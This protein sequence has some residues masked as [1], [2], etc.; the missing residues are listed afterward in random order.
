MLTVVPCVKNHPHGSK[1]APETIETLPPFAQLANGRRFICLVLAGAP[2]LTSPPVTVNI[3][4]SLGLKHTMYRNGLFVN[5]CIETHCETDEEQRDTIL[6]H[7][8]NVVCTFQLGVPHLRGCQ[9]DPISRTIAQWGDGVSFRSL[10][11]PH[12]VA[13]YYEGSSPCLRSPT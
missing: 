7:S 9:L 1:P 12:P 3:S 8:L 13:R 10:C 5:H 4:H 11:P 2:P 6:R